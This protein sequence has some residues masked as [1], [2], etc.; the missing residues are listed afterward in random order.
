MEAFLQ[1]REWL[2]SLVNSSVEFTEK[3]EK[4]TETC[5]QDNGFGTKIQLS[6]NTEMRA[7]VVR[8]VEKDCGPFVAYVV[9]ETPDGNRIRIEIQG[10]N[11]QGEI[12]GKTTHK[13]WIKYCWAAKEILVGTTAVEKLNTRE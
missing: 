3:E 13:K 2:S 9:T 4:K 7:S 5:E 6:T 8:G 10:C 12:Y 1:P 11:F